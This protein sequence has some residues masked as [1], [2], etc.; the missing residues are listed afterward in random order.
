MPNAV[1]KGV[2]LS[3]LLLA[4]CSDDAAAPPPPPCAVAAPDA[5]RTCTRDYGAA[6]ASC[7]ATN[8]APCAGDDAATNA[9]LDALAV[10]VEASCAD[11]ELGGL[12]RA[13]LGGRLANAC[14]SEASSAAWRTYGGPQGAVWAAA[15][16]AQRS[17]LTAAHQKATE[18]I[19]GSLGAIDAC[20]AGGDCGGVAAERDARASA[21]RADIDAACGDLASLIAVDSA[22]FVER[23]A[24][25]VDCLTST[26][27]FDTGPLALRC[28]P[29]HAQFEAPRGEWTM[30]PVDGDEWGTLC[31]DGSPY[32]FHVQLAP[33]GERLDRVVIGLQG[34]GVCLFAD[35]CG[36]RLEAEPGLFTAMDDTPP[37][38]GIMSDDPSQSQFAGWTKVFLPYCSQDVFAGGGVDED[39]GEG[40]TLPRHGSVNAR[41]AIQMVRDVLWKMMDAEGGD[42]FRPDAIVALFGG[43]SAGGYGTLYNYHWLLDDLQWPRTSAF[44]DAGLGLDNGLVLG[45]SGLGTIKIP[46]WGM[47]RN[48]PPYCFGGDCAEGEVIYN[49]ISPRLTLVPEQ[50]MLILTNQY[51]TTQEGDAFF[52]DTPSFINE[53][54]RSYCATRDL[55]GIQHY[56]TSA[57]SGSVHVVT[58]RPDHWLG[59]VDGEVMRDWFWRAVTEPTALEDRAEEGDFTTVFPGVDP[60]PCA[61]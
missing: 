19:D 28:G 54:R 39:L 41:A 24:R 1:A 60:F 48:L 6:I 42:G 32:A 34:G 57:S 47:Q 16:G 49:A 8:G 43:W 45:V 44:P 9:A 4:G 33:E 37:T 53:L 3:L 35:D 36:A 31:G 50:Q 61:L 25:Q 46:A 56:Y 18:L 10:S 13:A 14:E 26:G 58:L 51:D 55:P 20:L 17:C 29:S 11:G 7:Y 23:A 38:T 5:L 12:D 59:A 30:V 15:D 52:M 2:L 21:A 22:V 27:H 40:V